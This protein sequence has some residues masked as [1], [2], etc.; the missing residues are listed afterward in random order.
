M[1]FKPVY[2]FAT[3]LLLFVIGGT[4]LRAQ[5][6]M[7]NFTVV[8]K[9]GANYV[10]WTF[11]YNGVKLIGIQRSRDSANYYATIG[12]ATHPAQKENQYI[13]KKPV[14][15]ANYYRL[16]I[17]FTN[18]AYVFTKPT[19][20]VLTPATLSNSESQGPVSFQPSIFVYTNPD[21]NVNISIADAKNNDYTIRFYSADNRFL[22]E[23]NKINKPLLILDKSNFL[24]SGW[25]H[26]ELYRNGQIYEKWKFFIP[27]AGNKNNDS[28]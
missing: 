18:G 23:V 22:F 16:F 13:D 11:D 19:K 26:Y 5:D 17:M 24:H 27:E 9:G 4:S 12:H 10:N 15:G 8:N 1:S 2:F 28:D 6:L 21:G 25:F 7:K 14:A 20:I 3:L